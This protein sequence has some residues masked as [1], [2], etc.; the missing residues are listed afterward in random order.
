MLNHM[1]TPG[2]TH[3]S[4]PKS[5]HGSL[6]KLSL[7]FVLIA[8]TVRAMAGDNNSGPDAKKFELGSG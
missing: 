5:L 7:M 8:N 3:R 4:P 2:G 1:F 6:F